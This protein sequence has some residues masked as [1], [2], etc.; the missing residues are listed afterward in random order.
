MGESRTRVAHVQPAD[1]QA[2]GPATLAYAV[3]LAARGEVD[4]PVSMFLRP[5]STAFTGK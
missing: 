3:A 1:A 2:N 4:E 5:A